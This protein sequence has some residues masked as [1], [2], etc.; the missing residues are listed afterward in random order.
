MAEG[1][2]EFCGHLYCEAFRA[3]D[4]PVARAGRQRVAERHH[5]IGHLLLDMRLSF[6]VFREDGQCLQEVF[7][8]LSLNIVAHPEFREEAVIGVILVF[9][10]CECVFRLHGVLNRF[11][12]FVVELARTR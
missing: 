12:D 3:A 4:F 5:P 11:P 8:P 9:E 6:I 1:N 2:D 10:Q 7:E